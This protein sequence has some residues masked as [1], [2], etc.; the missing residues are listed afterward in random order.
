MP[1]II[2]RANDNCGHG[3]IGYL[4]WICCKECL[5]IWICQNNSDCPVPREG[6]FCCKKLTKMNTTRH[7][8]TSI[9]IYDHFGTN[10]DSSRLGNIIQMDHFQIAWTIMV[11]S[12]SRITEERSKQRGS[13]SKTKQE[14]NQVVVAVPE[15]M[16]QL[17]L[18]STYWKNLNNLG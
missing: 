14:W 6:L 1:N 17:H 4:F 11:G 12:V 9:K 2:Q 15:F 18:H 5:L 7:I 8:Q 16:P 13:A 10:W 3:W